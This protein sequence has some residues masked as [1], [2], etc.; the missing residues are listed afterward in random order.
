MRPCVPH[1]PTGNSTSRQASAQYGFVY[2]PEPTCPDE[3]TAEEPAA[4]PACPD[5]DAAEPAYPDEDAAEEPAA[6]LEYP[7][8]D[9]AE[10]I[11]VK[12]AYPD[13]DAANEV[14]ASYAKKKTRRLRD[15]STDLTMPKLTNHV[16]YPEDYPKMLHLDTS[17]DT[18]RKYLVQPSGQPIQYDAVLSWQLVQAFLSERIHE[19]NEPITALVR[20]ITVTIQTEMRMWTEKE[21][22][23]AL[24][25]L[26]ILLECNN[27]QSVDIHLIGNGELT[28]MDWPTQNAIRVITP[29]VRD[30]ITSFQGRLSIYK[31]LQQS[32]GQK[33]KNITSYWPKPLD[34]TGL[35]ATNSSISSVEYMMKEQV[36]YWANNG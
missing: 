6:K 34:K 33:N 13:Q 8:E 5:E 31:I 25:Q 16:Q 11:A 21:C 4:E 14:P 10:E 36:A 28:G 24:H 1:R 30:L 27:I 35:K 12:P 26:R 32:R 3:D 9:A 2:V 18:M 7:D 15:A 22:S 20:R 19:L 17:Q 23:N 29:A